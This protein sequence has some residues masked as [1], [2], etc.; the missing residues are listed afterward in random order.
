MNGK[1]FLIIVFIISTN[2]RVFSGVRV[3]IDF[4]SREN[5]VQNPPLDIKDSVD[6]RF[7]SEY[8]YKHK[9]N[10]L[11]IPSFDYCEN[12][13]Y[14]LRGEDPDRVSIFYSHIIIDNPVN[15]KNWTDH[16]FTKCPK[17]EGIW[18]KALCYSGTTE[19]LKIIDDLRST[20]RDVPKC[21]ETWKDIL[22]SKKMTRKR[23]YMLWSGFYSSGNEEYLN[24]IS[25]FLDIKASMFTFGEEKLRANAEYVLGGFAW[26]HELVYQF[27]VKKLEEQNISEQTREALNRIVEIA[28]DDEMPPWQEF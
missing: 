25:K 21:K 8:Y 16:I 27:C 6:Y 13:E 28:Q 11:I 12:E 5:R 9:K 1:L 19:S 23:L 4:K 24:E 17:L 14:A 2:F 7:F 22:K 20:G 26:T 15:V 18:L 3:N 10:E